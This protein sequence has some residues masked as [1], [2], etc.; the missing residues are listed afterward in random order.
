MTEITQIS[1]LP[2][3]PQRA[4][5]P[6]VF[7][8]RADAFVAALLPFREQLNEL[9]GDVQSAIAGNLVKFDG[10]AGVWSAGTFDAGQVVF[11]TPS[12]AFYIALQNGETAEPPGGDWRS[13]GQSELT[14]TVIGSGGPSDWTGSDPYVAT[15]TVSGIL[16][17]DVPIVDLD[18]SNVAF[19]DV[20][21]VQANWALV[22]RVEA[23]AD[24]EI[25]L[26]AI[27]EPTEDFALTI[28][29]VR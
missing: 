24:N 19:A 14:A 16:S 12:N 10:F 2:Q 25:K 18:L 28:K 21:D 29:V 3:P 26:Y 17:T 9:G 22:Y 11:H 1:P 20:V 15:L 8:G 4:D 5:A 7:A 6:D 27:D 13:I 23:S